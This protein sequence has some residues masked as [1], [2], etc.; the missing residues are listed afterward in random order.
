MA[1]STRPL[2]PD[3]DLS[4]NVLGRF[5][6]RPRTEREASLKKAPA[7]ETDS[8]RCPCRRNR[9]HRSRYPRRWLL[10]HSLHRLAVPQLVP[11]HR[12][13]CRRSHCRGASLPR[14]PS[15]SARRQRKSRRQPAADSLGRTPHPGRSII[16]EQFRYR[17]PELI[18]KVASSHIGNLRHRCRKPPGQLVELQ[19]RRKTKLQRF[20]FGLGPREF[21][22][23]KAPMFRKLRS[24]PIPVHRRASV[25]CPNSA[26]LP[27][28]KAG[29]AGMFLF[30]VAFQQL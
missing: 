15:P 23:S 29:V 25:N 26:I 17:S 2:L 18:A 11:R 5:E 22:K 3:H 7:Q 20:R 24:V 8:F 28:P 12:R 14:R 21:F 9:R 10:R 4:L 1:S 13:T 16:I 27:S 19:L 30:V 6:I